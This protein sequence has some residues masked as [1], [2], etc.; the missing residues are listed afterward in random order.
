MNISKA[1]I[2][3]IILELSCGNPTFEQELPSLRIV[4]GRPIAANSYPWLGSVGRSP[5]HL[6]PSITGKQ[7]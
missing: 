7:E 5:L 3:N 4:N 2:F 1:V 6:K